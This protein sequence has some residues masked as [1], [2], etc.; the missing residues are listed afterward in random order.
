MRSALLCP[1][2][3]KF[4]ATCISHSLNHEMQQ[5]LNV[6]SPT[7]V[8]CITL[9]VPMSRPHNDFWIS[10]LGNEWNGQSALRN[11]ALKQDKTRRNCFE[12][13]F[14]CS[15]RL[16]SG[17]ITIVSW[18][19]DAGEWSQWPTASAKEL[20]LFYSSANPTNAAV[21]CPL[22]ISFNRLWNPK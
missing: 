21:G 15:I 1:P 19:V 14:P 13:P 5:L 11:V 2:V 12:P 18:P 3:L 17:K 6:N 9:L 4:S 16:A 22:E 10:Q 8:R 7:L 20:S